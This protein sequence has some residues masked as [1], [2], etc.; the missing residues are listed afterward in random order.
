MRVLYQK[1]TPFV[2]S[3]LLAA[4]NPDPQYSTFDVANSTTNLPNGGGSVQPTPAATATPT[5]V[6]T[7]NPT[8]SPTPTPTVTATPTGT[9]TPTVTPTPTPTITATPTPT[10]T[11][12]PTPTP[13]GTPGGGGGGT[14][15]TYRDYSFDVSTTS[16][17][18]TVEVVF[19]VDDSPSMSDEQYYLSQGVK[20]LVQD[21]KGYNLNFKIYTT[22]NDG[23]KTITNSN[24]TYS[25]PT[26]PYAAVETFTLKAPTNVTNVPLVITETTS[27]ADLL[28]VS[29][30]F[31]ASVVS[32]GTNGSGNE[33]GAC[34]LL[35]TL[36]DEGPNK[37]FKPN[38]YAA[39]VLISDENDNSALSTCYNSKTWNVASNGSVFNSQIFGFPGSSTPTN[40]QQT[41]VEKADAFFGQNG[42]FFSAIIHD[43]TEDA[44][45][46][47]PA[48]SGG[49]TYGTRYRD[50]ANNITLSNV[51]SICSTDYSNALKDNIGTFVKDL[52][53]NTYSIPL[54]NNETIDSVFLIRTGLE[55]QLIKDVDYTIRGN[56]IEFVPNLLVRFDQIRVQIAIQ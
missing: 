27:D 45:Q 30:A 7:I 29:N 35:R 12:T 4:C 23:R 36:F 13:T 32:L 11:P 24:K 10:S 38:S 6:P 18:P 34:S 25:A 47:C 56:N 52:S 17:K 9:P 48:L 14:G 33:Q 39:F 2:V 55:I 5:I 46:G 40:L 8:V 50:L 22:T 26:I 44:K 31:A 20:S 16:L 53:V 37:I 3:I 41:F 19:I 28:N 49:S 51:Y 1:A 15:T 42:Y 21:M 43:Q 54:A